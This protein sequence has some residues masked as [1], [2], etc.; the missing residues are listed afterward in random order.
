[1]FLVILYGLFLSVRAFEDVQVSW[2]ATF[3]KATITLV[4]NG[5]NLT[6]QLV[7]TSGIVLCRRG[8]IICAL[9]VE[10][11]D[12]EVIE[13]EKPLVQAAIGDVGIFMTLK[14]TLPEIYTCFSVL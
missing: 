1:M 6:K 12:D 4:N 2:R 5:V 14:Y 9:T 13:S 10:V 3:S 7:Q 8:E 11:Q